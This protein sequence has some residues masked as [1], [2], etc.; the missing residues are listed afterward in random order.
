MQRF[1]IRHERGL[2]PVCR[3]LVVH[4]QERQLA[5]LAREYRAGRPISNLTVR[6]GQTPGPRCAGY[7]TRQALRACCTRRSPD[8]RPCRVLSRISAPNTTRGSPVWSEAG[9]SRPT[10]SV[11]AG[12]V[13]RGAQA[14]V[15]PSWT[16]RAD[17]DNVVAGG[18]FPPLGKRGLFT[19][20]RRGLSTTL[21][22]CQ[23]QCSE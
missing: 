20:R 2:A 12:A 22:S 11:A 23:H 9:S 15:V 6:G 3:P 5:R 16:P 21:R 14:I 10:R 13:D 19:S 17:A 1:G 18:K 8:I 7:G 4:R